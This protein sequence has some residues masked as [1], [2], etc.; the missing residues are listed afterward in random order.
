MEKGF[1]VNMGLRLFWITI[2]GLFA[3]QTI[4]TVHVLLS[5]RVLL[6]AMTELHDRG[7]LTVPNEQLLPSLGEMGPALSGG[8]FFTFTLGVGLT[9][10]TLLFVQTIRSAPGT[11]RFLFSGF[12]LLFCFLP[13]FS[14]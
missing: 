4:G 14:Q 13:D 6:L 7:L 9:V 12:L 11:S 3:S 5:N 10:L 1:P 2:A 8:L